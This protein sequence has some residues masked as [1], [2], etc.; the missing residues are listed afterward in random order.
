[1]PARTAPTSF[2]AA[3]ANSSCSSFASGLASEHTKTASRPATGV[4]RRTYD[5][6]SGNRCRTSLPAI[7]PAAAC[8]CRISPACP[9]KAKTTG[10]IGVPEGSRHPPLRRPVR[11][12]RRILERDQI[13]LCREVVESVSEFP[14]R[15]G[16]D[17]EQRLPALDN[18]ADRR[19][20]IDP[21]SRRLWR[22]RKLCCARQTAIVD[23]RD[24]TIP[25]RG[26]RTL[27]GRVRRLAHA[28]LARADRD[29]FLD[30]AAIVE[31]ARSER[32]SAALRDLGGEFEDAPGKAQCAR[33]QVARCVGLA[34]QNRQHIARLERGPDASADRLAA[35]GDHYADLDPDRVPDLL[36]FG[37][38]TRCGLG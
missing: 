12:S 1:M 2:A 22:A 37:A 13:L 3:T 36:Q 35:V 38:K 25:D 18:G 11:G 26:E 14:R 10:V 31:N 7:A 30:G 32:Q 6:P 9:G 16:M 4:S 28:P 23:L 29:E 34:P 33:P 5:S 19:E 27:V 24:A 15:L 20:E 21:R 17:H 8:N